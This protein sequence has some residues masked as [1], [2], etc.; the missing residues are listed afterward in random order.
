MKVNSPSTGQ[1]LLT[2]ALQAQQKQAQKLAS[3]KRI[4]SA[5]DDAAGLQ[6]ANRLTS[7]VNAASQGQRNLYDGIGLAQVYEQSLQNINNDLSEVNTLAVAAGNGIYTDADRAALQQQAQ[8]YLDNVQNTL[9]T[10]S[11]GGVSL[12]NEKDIAFNSGQSN[13]NLKVEDVGAALTSQNVFN[14]DLSTQAGAAA[15]NSALTQ[16][17]EYVSG[18]QASAGASINSFAS[19]ARNL[20]NQEINQAAARSRIEDADFASATAA[21]ASADI[22]SNTSVSVA[23]QARVSQQQALQLLS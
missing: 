7:T 16:A 4:N 6:I 5:A 11:F 13:L 18:L 8:G 19:Q 20:N 21:K 23:L 10:A 17:T 12:F 1:D 9:N 22:L 15:A 3:A 2:G 14:V